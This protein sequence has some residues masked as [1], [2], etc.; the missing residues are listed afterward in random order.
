MDAF[1]VEN[2]E[3]DH[4]KG[5]FIPFRPVPKAES[6][7]ILLSL[8]RQLHLPVSSEYTYICR[9]IREN[10]VLVPGVDAESDDFDLKAV[11]RQLRFDFGDLVYLN[12]SRLDGFDEIR[13]VDLC[14]RFD[15]IW[16]PSSDDLDVFDHN[17]NWII[18]IEHS[19]SIRA[20]RIG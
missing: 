16:Y 2:Y 13:F 8:K 15:D 4:G 7:Q 17:L 14:E 18:S 10:S 9:F 20:L 19:G 5:T 11:T 12:W 1:K 6:N 3:R